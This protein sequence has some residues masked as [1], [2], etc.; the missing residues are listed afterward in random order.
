MTSEQEALA[1]R[2]FREALHIRLRERCPEVLSFVKTIESA[3]E[4]LQLVEFFRVTSEYELQPLEVSVCM[5][6]VT[7]F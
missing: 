6:R 3:T 2:E 5:F 1:A 7:A 4:A